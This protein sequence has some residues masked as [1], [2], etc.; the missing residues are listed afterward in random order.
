MQMRICV[1]CWHHI[2]ELAEKE[3]TEGRC[4]ACRTPY[5]KERIVGMAAS[6][7]RFAAENKQKNQKGKARAS[8]EPRKHLSTVRVIQRNLVYIIGLPVNL[9]DENLLE[10]K[11]YFGQYGKILKVSISRTTSSTNQQSSNTSVFSVYITYG[12]EEEA[13][14]CIQ[15]V[16]NYILAGKPL[17]ACFGTTKYCHAWLR[18]VNCSNPDC[19]YLHEL[20]SQEDSFTKDEIISTYT[21]SRLPHIPSCNLQRRAGNMLPPSEDWFNSGST[22]ASH[23]VK[24]VSNVSTGQLKVA[25][26]CFRKPAILPAAAYWGVSTSN[27]RLVSSS[28]LYSQTS[29]KQTAE[30][31]D[32]NMST[33]SS[34]YLGKTQ[35]SERSP[36]FESNGISEL[37][38]IGVD[39]AWDD[40]PISTSEVVESSYPAF[41]SKSRTSLPS[42]CSAAN[43]ECETSGLLLSSKS[44]SCKTSSIPIGMCA[45]RS[46]SIV[47]HD[48]DCSFSSSAKKIN[49]V[50][51]IAPK[52]LSKQCVA[53]SSD[54][55]ASNDTDNAQH[56]QAVCLG[57]SP[58]Y[59]DIYHEGRTT[60]ILDLST[61]SEAPVSLYAHESIESSSLVLE[62]QKLIVKSTGNGG[63][64][65]SVDFVD[66]IHGASINTSTRSCSSCLA[67][68]LDY[69]SHKP[70]SIADD[71]VT[72]ALSSES[73]ESSMHFKAES[74]L[75][76]FG[77]TENAPH[78]E[79]ELKLKNMCKPASTSDSALTNSGEG[80]GCV[81]GFNELNSVD[82]D[83][84]VHNGESSI[85]T[86]ILSLDFDPWDD[87]VSLANNFS[88]L[89]GKDEEQD[90][91]FKLSELLS[92]KHT[93]Q[94]RFSFARQENQSELV[95]SSI[96][97]IEHVQ[98][99]PS[100]EESHANDFQQVFMLNG[101]MDGNSIASCS[102]RVSLHSP[103]VAPAILL[104]LQHKYIILLWGYLQWSSSKS[105]L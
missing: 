60:S 20:G 6:C 35:V 74:N 95:E 32:A 65:A 43:R 25:N 92:T 97:G 99:Y 54:Q 2:M 12:R 98:K 72:G 46:A 66:S 89:L 44:A 73:K 86:N 23:S 83:A 42:G 17:R 4:P 63:E 39:S 101:L 59:V 79:Q 19:L 87:S 61:T 80:F 57:S 33:H 8:T 18:N 81:D 70:R 41:V 16:H 96:G 104:S 56:V 62:P 30:E 47:S 55:I 91:S 68:S 76:V 11:E 1:W 105:V 52:S 75:A 45:T 31:T 64:G 9:C 77:Q 5:D 3:E 82:E 14:R 34:I 40:D 48:K 67:N 53:S 102:A 85:I 51:G 29:T 49:D 93:N 94:S 7:E 103:A 13:V 58:A 26:G 38:T 22:S 71:H 69:A 21:R 100:L 15:A 84:S 24:S 36:T 90:G 27:T 50:N 28:I 88:K 10:R 37:S 78:N